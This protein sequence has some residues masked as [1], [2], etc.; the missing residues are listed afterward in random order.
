MD[1]NKLLFLVPVFAIIL[2]AILP[3]VIPAE[4]VLVAMIVG[5]LLLGIVNLTE[6]ETTNFFLAYIAL[7]TVSGVGLLANLTSRMPWFGI[8]GFIDAIFLN[9]VLLFGFAILPPA[10]RTAAKKLADR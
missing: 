5:G 1:M 3:A 10:F 2:G 7:A 8:G 4:W 6:K 9:M